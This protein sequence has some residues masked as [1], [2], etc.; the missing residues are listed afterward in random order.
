MRGSHEAADW[1][2]LAAGDRVGR[3]TIRQFLGRGGMGRVY[4]ADGPQGPRALKVI[5]PQYI[6]QDDF[7][8]RFRLE[9][10][11]GKRIRHENVVRTYG[12]EMV[13][14]DG[15]DQAILVMEYV[16]G[17]TL[18]QMQR[19]LGPLPESLVRDI[20]TGI[21]R[22]LEAIHEAGVIHRDLKPEN[23]MI[24]EDHRVKIMDLGVARLRTD[25][26]RLSHAG[27]FVGSLLFAAPE[28]LSEQAP[29]CGP[30]ADLYGV[31]LLLYVMITGDHPF[32]SGSAGEI[33]N[34]HLNTV[35]EPLRRHF[36]DT[37]PFLEAVTGTLLQKVPDKRFASA[38]ALRETLEAG[39]S[40]EWWMH[41]R[42]E[43]SDD[44]GP[45]IAVRRLGPFR[46]RAGELRHL[47]ELWR[48]TTQGRGRV[49]LVQGED[50]IGKSRLIDAFLEGLRLP[51]PCVGVARSEPGESGASFAAVRRVVLDLLRGEEAEVVLRE[52]LPG[53]AE[54]IDAFLEFLQTGE[55]P[56][57]DTF[58]IQT[59]HQLIVQAVR[60]LSQDR[61]RL[62]VIEDV[63]HISSADRDVALDLAKEAGETGMLLVCTAR[64]DLDPEY[65]E[66][67]LRAA[68][69]RSLSLKPLDRQTA[70]AFVAEMVGSLAV[71]TEIYGPLLARAGGNPLFLAE[72]VAGLKEEGVLREMPDGSWQRGACEAR[73]SVPP[74]LATLLR[75][76]IEGFPAA[77]VET[78][79]VAAIQGEAF[80]ARVV[81][82][83]LDRPLLAVHEAL[84]LCGRDARVVSEQGDVFAFEPALVRDVLLDRVPDEQRRRLHRRVAAAMELIAG[85]KG[86]RAAAE[87]APRVVL[88]YLNGDDPTAAMPLLVGAMR[89]LVEAF[90]FQ[91]A[92][93]LADAA[94][95]Y[96]DDLDP[97]LVLRVLVGR[98]RCYEILG[99]RDDERRALEEVRAFAK[100]SE[101]DVP[102]A[103]LDSHGRLLLARGELER[104]ER[105]F[106]QQLE[107]AEGQTDRV[108][109]AR[110]RRNLAAAA[111][112][113]RDVANSRNLLESSLILARAADH[114]AEEL[115]AT[116]AL[117][118]VF[119][120]E[121]S[122]DRA[123]AHR[124]RSLDL[125]VVRG[126]VGA[127]CAAHA[128]L[129]RLALRRGRAREAQVHLDRQLDTA[130]LTGDRGAECGALRG[131][132]R[133]EMARGRLAAASR[134]LAAA[135]RV[136]GELTR[137]TDAAGLYVDLARL[138]L[139]HGD[140]AGLLQHAT[141]AL[142]K[143]QL[144]GEAS[145]EAEALTLCGVAAEERG[146]LD[147]ATDWFEQAEQRSAGGGR[148]RD[149]IQARLGLARTWR[150]AGRSDLAA[151]A[152]RDVVEMARRHGL[153]G[154]RI[155][156][157]AMRAAAGE[158][159]P[160]FVRA[161]LIRH[162]DRLTTHERLIVYV[163]L[164]T[165]T[166]D[167]LFQQEAC[168]LVADLAANLADRPADELARGYSLYRRALGPINVPRDVDVHANGRGR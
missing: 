128:G 31:G 81:A 57:D 44:E 66:R 135:R 76:R 55:E 13:E 142:S 21:A 155:V 20:A 11:A 138:H 16:R 103:A 164:A 163:E 24:T 151:T 108:A 133:L 83:V 113:R 80:D 126:D 146:D 41:R 61:P 29:R 54:H 27:H 130:R 70:I 107:A 106:R 23:V 160:S 97:R 42:P 4:R 59:L 46:G 14:L 53:A 49:V 111:V 136:A 165:A 26:I 152:L 47:T 134:T 60:G 34:A 10:G 127:V 84:S 112:Q 132:A 3:Y 12:C 36:S 148:P 159:S 25:E 19:D 140:M 154:P 145:V 161:E 144:L 1:P 78:L 129:A 73:E 139:L 33:I 86:P 32:P 158:A 123:L 56:T 121:G 77:V 92:L 118:D 124:A 110:A 63:D 68:G 65:R 35:P 102:A 105:F 40:S 75:K 5:H 52:A 6:Q 30:P 96:R 100:A 168:E 2:L 150:R 72:I 74:T 79:E 45:S 87:V 122:I 131:L 51:V 114:P 88:H 95:R 119:E 125:A 109:E 162:S 94:L 157:E 90:N 149:A 64:A 98:A 156:A 17:R 9:A 62:V 37:S 58:T 18:L 7:Q 15:R 71:A 67:L 141:R 101:L 143:A 137:R 117:A 99:R 116:A 153:P 166:G 120:A 43:G 22:G 167:S 115:A 69:A 28:Q 82:R 91:D 50:G 48:R 38:R 39:E 104:A 8:Q 89:R 147:E 85:E 93:A